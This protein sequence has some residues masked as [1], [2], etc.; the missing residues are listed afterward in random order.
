MN[1]FVAELEE[2]F[3]DD[4]L[5]A[6]KVFSVDFLTNDGFFTEF[7]KTIDIDD[8]EGINKI[9]RNYGLEP[10]DGMF[11]MDTME[12]IFSIFSAEKGDERDEK[13]ETESEREPQKLVRNEKEKNQ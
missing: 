11:I 2:N 10:A 12:D 7:E 6:A 4:E 1:K 3:D 5:E 8:V 13:T 9:V